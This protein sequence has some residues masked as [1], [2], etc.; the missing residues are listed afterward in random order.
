MLTCTVFNTMIY[1]IYLCTELYNLKT[2]KK[3]STFVKYK[4]IKK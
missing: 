2:L 1:N 4:K 3:K